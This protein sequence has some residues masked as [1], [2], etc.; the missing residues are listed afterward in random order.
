[1]DKPFIVINSGLVDLMDSEELRT[2]IGHELGHVKSGHAVYR[3]MLFNLIALAQRIQWLPIGELALRPIIWGLEE[4][5]RKSELSCDRAGLL[6]SQDIDASRRALMKMAGGSRLSEMNADAFHEQARE[7]DAVPDLRDSVLKILQLQGNTHPFAVV[8][9]AELDHWIS[10]G[11]YE[12]ILGG[13]YLRSEEDRNASI[14]EEIKGAAKSYQEAWN[15]SEDP[16]IGMV[17]G[18]LGNMARAGSGLFDRFS[19][20]GNG[21]DDS[22]D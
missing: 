20:R 18:G 9:Y 1:M 13:D 5:F 8:R 14:S 4:W 21:E 22:D 15:R 10:S 19:N 2:V 6:A 12:R 7:Y 16:L 17:R 11:A 3:T